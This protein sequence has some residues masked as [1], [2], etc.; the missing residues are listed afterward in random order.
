MEGV[1]PRA[2]TNCTGNSF[3]TTQLPEVLVAQ[4]QAHDNKILGDTALPIAEVSIA[5]HLNVVIAADAAPI[6]ALCGAR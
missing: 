2:M 4:S 1:T 6:S 5:T 3:S